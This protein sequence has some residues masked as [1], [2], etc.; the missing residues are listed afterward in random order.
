M[1]M[2]SNRYMPT[3][4][5]AALAS[6]ITAGGAAMPGPRRHTKWRQY[7]PSTAGVL[8]HRSPSKYMPHQGAK[9]CARRLR[10]AKARPLDTFLNPPE[11]NEGTLH[12]KEI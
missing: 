2:K 3:A 9:E 12:G 8:G 4:M 6:A 5:L 1:K 7:K 10:Q 11:L